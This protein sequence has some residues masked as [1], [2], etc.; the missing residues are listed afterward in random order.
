MV[1]AGLWCSAGE[2][3]G[4]LLYAYACLAV[5]WYVLGACRSPCCV[6]VCL[7]SVVHTTTV[8]ACVS[9]V[10]T[11]C[12]T[13]PSQWCLVQQQLQAWVVGAVSWHRCQPV[14]VLVVCCAV[15]CWGLLCVYTAGFQL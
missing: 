2:P 9:A 15:L 12:A 1:L 8:C 6:A 13:C 10:V 3:E 5:F 14:G 4:L 7:L 11:C